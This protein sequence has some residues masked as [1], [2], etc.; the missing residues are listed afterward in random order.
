MEEGS[1][2]P[3]S[4][5]SEN[6]GDPPPDLK[7]K[8]KMTSEQSDEHPTC[9]I[10][11]SDS[12]RAVRGKIDSCDHYYCF[13]CIMEWARVESRCPQCKFRFHSITRPAVLGRYPCSRV[14]NVPQRDQVY[15]PL[16][17]ESTQ[18]SDPFEHVTCSICERSAD[19][20]L[21]LLCDLC[22]SAIHT[23]CAG[24]GAT[25]P[26]CDWY[27]PDCSISRDEHCQ[28]MLADECGN[29]DS[30]MKSGLHVAQSPVS[31]TER[32]PEEYINAVSPRESSPQPEM[33]NDGRS[34]SSN[35][36][37]ESETPVSFQTQLVAS[38]V[39]TVRR[40]R[41]VHDIIRALR[42]NWNALRSGSLDFSS[43]MLNNGR[44]VDHDREVT[45]DRR[46]K[47]HLLTSDNSDHQNAKGGASNETCEIS[48]QEANRAWKQMKMAKS[49][50]DSQEGIRINNAR[51]CSGE[52]NVP[53]R[54]ENLCSRS[55]A[56]Q[57]RTLTHKAPSSK[58]AHK[59]SIGSLN[60]F[61]KERHNAA[62]SA[63]SQLPYYCNGSSARGESLHFKKD[64]TTK[65]FE[66][67]SSLVGEYTP[68]GTYIPYPVSGVRNSEICSYNCSGSSVLGDSFHT[69]NVPTP[70]NFKK[71]SSFVGED[72][73]FGTYTHTVSG[74]HNSKT[75]SYNHN[76]SSGQ[77]DGSHGRKIP[78]TKNFEKIS[79]LVGEETPFGTY[80]PYSVSGVGNIGFN[81][82]MSDGSS[83]SKMDPNNARM[84]MNPDGSI[85][86]PK[87][88]VNNTDKDE[89]Q[90]LVKL[91]L[92]LSSK[93]MHLG[94]DK[95]KEIARIS[96]HTVLAACGWETSISKAQAFPKPT[97]SHSAQIKQLRLAKSSSKKTYMPL[98]SEDASTKTMKLSPSIKGSTDL[99]LKKQPNIT[100]KVAKV[101]KLSSSS[102][103]H[104]T[105]DLFEGVAE[106]LKMLNKDYH[107][108]AHRS[109]PINND[110]PLE[111][112][113]LKP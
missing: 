38:S 57:D 109:P 66:K 14:V 40:C 110:Q 9:G 82:C 63:S 53:K 107:Q 41:N 31:I 79:S 101:S 51:K 3:A 65:N 27:C 42:A 32:V 45:N 91:N 16:G 85:L 25:V 97:C 89:V 36:V 111:H 105:Q 78:T 83:Y 1:K 106:L 34:E 93:D 47:M 52:R 6:L 2:P 29:P 104:E 30:F 98:D 113:V 90:T 22:D 59:Q 5:R 55:F 15:H 69:K 8:E 102:S 71:I 33:Q 86:E 100:T 11:L 20:E 17:N 58:M 81:K 56:T 70:K 61:H 48:S 37:S 21:L 26:E 76:G 80:T 92:N 19:E 73:P 67:V 49:W 62:I 43:S 94:A 13:I 24:L 112:H 44:T 18:I 23:Y 12:G 64:P 108:R 54:T 74:A 87:K 77:G 99:Q 96:T 95:F 10:C 72:T 4:K 103:S 39:R 84:D 68:F 46:R 75:P 35:V 88:A 50:Q 28:A 60:K 7:G